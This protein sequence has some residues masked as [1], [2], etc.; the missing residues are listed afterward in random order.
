MRS[1]LCGELRASHI[2]ENVTLCGWLHK[3]RLVSKR[4]PLFAPLKDHTGVIQ[5]IVTKDKVCVM[6]NAEQRQPIQLGT[7]NSTKPIT[8]RV[9]CEY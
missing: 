8:H 2:G 4:G 9:C 6:C 7:T 3:L 5:L 1:H